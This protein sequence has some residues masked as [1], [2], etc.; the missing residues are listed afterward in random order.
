MTA[1]A[2]K[3]PRLRL[4]ILDWC[5]LAVSVAVVGGFSWFAYARSV[6]PDRLVI[7]ASGSTWIYPL[8]V[9]R[10]EPVHGP[11]GDTI[12]VIKAGKAFV[13]DSP[14]KNK[15]CVHMPP[16]SAPGQWIACLPNGVF[17]RVEGKQER[18]TDETSY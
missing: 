11:L 16:I 18:E 5:A 8:D 3:T 9:D 7:E 15:L 2:R 13:E 14:C 1:R 12:V 6:L 10:R 17:L 4:T